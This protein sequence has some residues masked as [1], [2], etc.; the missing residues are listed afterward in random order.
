MPPVATL[1]TVRPKT[2]KQSFGPLG[3]FYFSFYFWKR[4][5]GLQDLKSE[6]TFPG[7]SF[8]KT[9]P[10]P[11]RRSH[12]SKVRPGSASTAWLSAALCWHISPRG[13]DQELDANSDRET[14]ALWR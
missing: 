8:L 2:D 9:I 5:L 11:P 1:R 10:G 6:A 7:G 3:G 12:Q 13:T 4:G 14:S